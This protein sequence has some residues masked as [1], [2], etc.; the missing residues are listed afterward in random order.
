MKTWEYILV[1]IAGAVLIGFLSGFGGYAFGKRAR[2]VQRDTITRVEL[3]VDTHKVFVPKLVVQKIIDKEYIPV[4]DTMRIH[5]TIFV[6]LER[7]Q[8]EY[9]DSEY[10]AIV[11]GIRPSL[12]FIEVYP[13][14]KI[15]TQTITLSPEHKPTRFGIG[16]QVGFGASYGIINKKM[17]CGPYIGI[18]MSYNF[19]RF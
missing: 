15:I 9:A 2:I 18:G 19:V 5:D 8:K 12:D 17:D 11:S 1:A 16:A 10:R 4:V 13:K 6:A 3:R 14:T 7:E